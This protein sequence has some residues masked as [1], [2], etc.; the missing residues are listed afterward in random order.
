MLGLSNIKAKKPEEVLA[1]MDI[2]SIGAFNPDYYRH[3]AFL[4]YQTVFGIIP[5][6]LHWID[7]RQQFYQLFIFYG[8]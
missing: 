1:L 4:S 7:F 5:M 3:P 8:Q 6:L 2:H